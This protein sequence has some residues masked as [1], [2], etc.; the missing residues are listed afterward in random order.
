MLLQR[1][2]RRGNCEILQLE[3]S[4][5]HIRSSEAWT[6]TICETPYPLWAEYNVPVKSRNK[7]RGEILQ[8]TGRKWHGS[9]RQDCSNV[10]FLEEPDHSI[11]KCKDNE[12]EIKW[13]TPH[14]ACDRWWIGVIDWKPGKLPKELEAAAQLSRTQTE[15]ERGGELGKLERIPGKLGERCLAAEIEQDLGNVPCRKTRKAGK[16]PAVWVKSVSVTGIWELHE[17]QD[18]LT[19]HRATP[20]YRQVFIAC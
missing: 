13:Q 16:S 11:F 1:M 18:N 2:P 7:R 14:D 9:E 10:K 15:G 8:S 19:G 12:K 6:A 20:E 3:L 17:I 5:T 4:W